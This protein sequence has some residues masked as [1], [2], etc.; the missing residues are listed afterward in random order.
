MVNV[1][2]PRTSWALFVFARIAAAIVSRDKR[3]ARAAM[4]AA[5]AREARRAL[6]DRRRRIG[7]KV[8]V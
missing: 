5:I 7:I 2:L 8:R 4:R 1:R 6:R 3:E